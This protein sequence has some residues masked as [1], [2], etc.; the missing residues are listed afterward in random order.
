MFLNIDLTNFN[1]ALEVTGVGML[2]IFIFMVI[3]CETGLVVTPFLPG[4]SLLFIIGS[5][6]SVGKLN[7]WQILLLLSLAAIAGNLINYTFGY[8]IGQ[9]IFNNPKSLFLN[10]KNLKKTQ[11]FYDRH[12]GKT[13]ILARF[14]PIIRTFAPFVAGIGRMHF[15]RFMIY[16]IIGCVFW[17]WSFT[18]AGFFFG[19]IPL[20]QKYMMVLVLLIIL[21][22]FIPVIYSYIKS[23]KKNK[24]PK[25][26]IPLKKSFC[27]K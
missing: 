12:G 23:L 22:S 4:D 6:A 26:T 10:P 9:K 27:S 11:D 24:K 8:F 17:I 7:I 19:N 25:E 14:I 5:M 3:F 20:V 18:L 1:K 16:N 21:T 15:I 13:I 2:G